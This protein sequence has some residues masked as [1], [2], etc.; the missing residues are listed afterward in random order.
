[1]PIP[2]IVNSTANQIQEL[3]TNSDLQLF[4]TNKLLLGTQGEL[5]ISHDAN[6][7]SRI[8]HIPPSAG[9]D[10][11]L[12]IGPLG[13]DYTA[14]P[15]VGAQFHIEKKITAGGNGH[16]FIT[17]D[18]DSNET[19]I[20]F[21]D[22]STGSTK[23]HTTSTG[24]IITGICTTGSL[25]ITDTTQS[26]SKDTGALVV[27][28]GVGIEKK[29]FVGDDIT[30]F[31]TSDIKLKDN[32]T[33]IPNALDKVISISGNTFKWNSE[34]DYEGK[35]DTG[36]IAQEIEKLGLP[37]ITSTRENGT[38]AVRYERLVPLLIQ[39]IKE[40]DEKVKSLEV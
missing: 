37:G 28:G 21:A 32:I 31:D 19:R 7:V 11:R 35:E 18:Y 40:L 15:L 10:L 13:G 22:S 17:C 26:T 25:V 38:K 20:Q 12:Q 36:V 23:L 2:L 27:E 24:V 8:I 3:Q 30:A 14:S 6:G 34:S 39:A 16:N 5:D 4:D 33:P 29:L 9:N 1:M